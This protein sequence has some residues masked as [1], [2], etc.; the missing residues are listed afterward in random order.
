MKN[1]KVIGVPTLVNGEQRIIE[2]GTGNDISNLFRPIM[3]K[4]AFDN[5][6]ILLFDEETGRAKRMNKSGFE[7]EDIKQSQSTIGATDTQD[8]TSGS[9]CSAWQKHHDGWPCRLW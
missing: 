9:V 5:D 2:F 4:H 7:L 8:E 6:E 1:K 3:I